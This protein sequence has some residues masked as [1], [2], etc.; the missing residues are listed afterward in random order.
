M[1]NITDSLK[2]LGPGSLLFKVYINQKFHQ[3]CIDPGD[4]DLLGLKH[5]VYYI[6]KAFPFRFRH[7]S[8]FFQRCTDSIHFIMKTQGH[9]NLFN[10]IDNVIYTGLP[11]DIHVAYEHL[12][13]L[14]EELN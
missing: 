1:D 2:K 9:H 4:L 11:S 14:L 13:S 12:I 5:G 8:V 10:Y 3:L 7:G 6:N